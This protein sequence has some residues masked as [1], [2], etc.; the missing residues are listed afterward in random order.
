VFG[1]VLKG[2]LLENEIN[3]KKPTQ[4]NYYKR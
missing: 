4:N 3:K 2:M 1:F